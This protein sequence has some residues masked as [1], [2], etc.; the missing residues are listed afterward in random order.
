[1]TLGHL[2]LGHLPCTLSLQKPSKYGHTQPIFKLF[3][4]F[5]FSGWWHNLFFIL[6]N[7]GTNPCWQV[8][9]KLSGRVFWGKKIIVDKGAGHGVKK[10]KQSLRTLYVDGPNMSK[11]PPS[12][13]HKSRRQ[14]NCQTII[15]RRM[16]ELRRFFGWR[17]INQIF[18]FAYAVAHLRYGID[19]IHQRP[20]GNKGFIHKR[21]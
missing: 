17:C 7:L 13:D 21:S 15:C 6:S 16:W 4:G 8:H 19:T 1:M 2:P 20:W 5:T 14:C 9:H 11:D 3:F 18:M 10:I 12:M